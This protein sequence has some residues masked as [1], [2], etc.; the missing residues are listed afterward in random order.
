MN[1]ATTP[2]GYVRWIL[3][4]V[5]AV[6]F[7]MF[8][9]DIRNILLYVLTAT[10]LV[11]FVNI[12]VN[13]LMSWGIRRFPA[14]IISLVGGILFVYLLMLM[15]L[16]TLAEQFVLLGEEIGKGI[17]SGIEYWNSGQIQERWTFL[18]DIEFLNEGAQIDIETVRGIGEQVLDTLG[19]LGGS[20]LPFLGGIANTLLSIVIIF[21]LTAFF[22]ANPASYKNGFVQLFPLWYRHRIRHI[23]D[24]LATLLRRWLY[25]Q[26]IGMTITA[27]GTF[28][29]LTLVGIEQAAALAVLTAIFSFVPNFGELLAVLVALAVGA[30]QA[31][32][33]LGWIV[34]VIYGVSFV[35]G[36]IIGPLIAAETL[37][38]PPVLILLGQIV[39]AGFF[40]VMGI[41]LAVPIVAIGMVIVQEVYI[42]D[43]LGD[44]N[45]FIESDSQ[46]GDNA[47]QYVDDLMP[48]GV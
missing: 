1:Q 32:D 22:L 29:G 21:F 42:K 25:A 20:V 5:C 33:S 12:P 8:L 24:R 38:I 36:Q 15:V 47:G 13:K 3:M 26:M 43:I 17:D 46:D 40:G 48:D 34:V 31:P 41:V 27:T 11:I 28:I 19:Q 14:F 37:N 18:Q 44:D 39:V 16:P 7:T 10:I 30:V 6:L 9:W 2:V 23:L 4:A 45:K 35:Q